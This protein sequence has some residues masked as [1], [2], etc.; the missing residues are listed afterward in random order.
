ML[1]FLLS[2]YLGVGMLHHVVKACLTTEGVLPSFHGTRL[3][4]IMAD[5]LKSNHNAEERQTP[6]LRRPYPK[7]QLGSYL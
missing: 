4:S 7:S 2:K 1:S 6:I 5:A 3:V